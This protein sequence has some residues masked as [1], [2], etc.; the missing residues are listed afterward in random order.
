MIK[1]K[2]LW[3]IALA[4]MTMS[5]M[6][7]AC[8]T[9]SSDSGNKSE[10]ESLGGVGVYSYK[11]NIADI[12]KA[13]GGSPESPAFSVMLLNE[14]TLEACKAAANFKVATAAE[15]EYQ[16]GAY[17]NLKIADTSKT[18]DFVVYGQ[19]AVE[20]V[21][22]YYTGVV[23]TIDDSI[24]TLTVDMTKLVKTELKGLWKDTGNG[25]EAVMTAD[26]LVDLTGYKPYVLALGAG[27]GALMNAWSADLMAMEEGATFPAN[28]KKDAPVVP[29]CKDLDS[30]NGS[31]VGWAETHTALTDNAFTFTAAG[32]DQFAFTI[33][34][35]GFKVCGV[36][37]TELG[38][39]FKLVEGADANITF[40]AGVLTAGTEYTA[41]LV[42]KG[43]HEA[44][45]KVS[46]K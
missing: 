32:E 21:Y 41:T 36:E 46:A 16:I 37:V 20:D 4:T 38:K 18:G 34:D 29:T 45:V 25:D 14:T 13:W 23:A 26:D 9:G 35:W 6:L 19:N 43:N 7:V 2:N 44:Y 5:A 22:Q 3:K 42:V 27:E 33:G 1:L 30:Y 15:P 12:S 8:D 10:E 40:A 31:M 28:A 39:E 24:F 11:V 17:G